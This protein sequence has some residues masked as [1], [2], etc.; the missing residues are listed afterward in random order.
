[1]HFTC[2]GG[3]GR[4]IG[5]YF[6]RP[7]GSGRRIRTY[8]TCPGGFGRLICTCF[9]CPGGSGRLICMYS[10]RCAP[11]RRPSLILSVFLSEKVSARASLTPIPAPR[12]GG[13]TGAYGA[14][15][16]GGTER[17]FG[18]PRLSYPESVSHAES[19]CSF[20]IARHRPSCSNRS[21]Q[22]E[23]EPQGLD[24]PFKGKCF[25]CIC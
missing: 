14:R 13:R 7:G 11:S 4:L 16:A 17:A 2:P 23:E 1:M 25:W 6:T 12:A 18:A 15:R 3:S 5:M 19:K 10:I 22:S 8:F 20:R 24:F 21:M 9:A